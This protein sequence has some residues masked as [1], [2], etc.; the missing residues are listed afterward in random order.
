MRTEFLEEES[1]F[2][3]VQELYDAMQTVLAWNVIFE[4]IHDRVIT[5]VSRVWNVGWK[6]WILFE[7]DTYFAAY[8]L[9]LSN[10]E[11]A[12]ANALAMTK[13]ITDHGFVPNF[14]SSVT[15]S[16]DRSQPPVG[17]FVVKEIYRRFGEKW[18]L[19]EV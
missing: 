10:K 11:L 17:S 8:M 13:E 1:K 16:E 6:G 14:A 12:Y 5:P 2:Q 15:T 18:F 3:D 9:S 19:E 7:W 4:P